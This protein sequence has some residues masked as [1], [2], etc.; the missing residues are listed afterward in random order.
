MS[1]EFSKFFSN[2]FLAEDGA[3]VDNDTNSSESIEV[4]VY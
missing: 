3:H 2:F 1:I 4:A